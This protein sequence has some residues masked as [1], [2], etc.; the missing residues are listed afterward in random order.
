LASI[1]IHF[2]KEIIPYIC[3]DLVLERL[4]AIETR[5]KDLRISREINIQSPTVSSPLPIRQSAKQAISS[6]FGANRGGSVVAANGSAYKL[7]SLAASPTDGPMSDDAYW[8]GLDDITL[9]EQMPASSSTVTPSMDMNTPSTPIPDG[10]TASPYYAEVMQKLK[11]VFKL[12][13]FRK[14]QLEAVTATLEGRDVFVLMPTG[15]GKSL[16]YQ[17]PAICTT[18]KTQGVTIVISPL[19]ALMRDQVQSLQNKCIAALLSNSETGS[20][21]WKN[22]IVSDHKPNLWYITPEKLRDSPKVTNILD[23]LYHQQQLARFVVDEAHC[24][25]TWGQDFRD[26]VRIFSGI[27][28]N[29]VNPLF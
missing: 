24:I 23:R 25:S 21:D 13:S 9:D 10:L 4:A 29:P 18:G 16:C 22:L 12:P 7:A 5:T 28:C 8:G 11:G 19:I 20:E 17:L 15:G 2:L 26:A 6:S 14:N 3:R 1:D 27:L